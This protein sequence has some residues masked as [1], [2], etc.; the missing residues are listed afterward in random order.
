MIHCCCFNVFFHHFR[1][2]TFAIM[3]FLWSAVLDVLKN[4]EIAEIQEDADFIADKP[5][6]TIIE[7]PMKLKLMKA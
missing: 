5:A 3:G 7:E 2:N 4:V 6:V 1:S